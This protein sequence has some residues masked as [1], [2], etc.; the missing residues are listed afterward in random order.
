[1]VAVLHKP[2]QIIY[3]SHAFERNFKHSK[4]SR[5]KTFHVPQVIKPQKFSYFKTQK[6]SWVY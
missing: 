3:V 5:L 6:F 1:M 4:V 2:L